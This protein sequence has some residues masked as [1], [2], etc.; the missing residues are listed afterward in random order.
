MKKTILFTLAVLALLS[1][2]NRSSESESKVYEYDQIDNIPYSRASDAY[3]KE[4]CLLD[5]YY[6]EG[7]ENVPVV[8]WFH[9]GG[10]T[11]GSKFVPQELKNAG[12]VVIAVNYRLIP[13]VG[14]DG[15]IDDAAA[16]VAW[17]FENA[18]KYG[19]KDVYVCGHSAGGY[20]TSMIGLDK[21]WLA[22][23]GVDANDIKALFP[24]SGQAITHFAHRN[25]QGIPALQATVDEY[26]PL[27]YVRGDASPIHIISADR[28]KEMN[29]RYEEQA[30]FWRMLRLSG[31]HNSYLY[32]LEGYDHG[33]M[34]SPGLEMTRKI[35]SVATCLPAVISQ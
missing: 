20:L 22:K 33:S 6:P 31:L 25:L 24:L 8:V 2:H 3:S 30:Y 7:A 12:M 28:E 9:G 15:C 18:A 1:C 11:G 13:H 34:C 14:I 23:Y 4:R 32:E 29:G 16:A 17:A 19:G 21:K 26:A 5:V 27:T 10:L 35:I